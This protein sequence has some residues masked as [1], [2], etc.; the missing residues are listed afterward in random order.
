MPVPQ[1][2]VPEWDG[3]TSILIDAPPAV[4]WRIVQELLKSSD[5]QA[6]VRDSKPQPGTKRWWKR[7]A[8]LDGSLAVVDYAERLATERIISGETAPFTVFY[9]S[10]SYYN[11]YQDIEGR[12]ERLIRIGPSLGFCLIWKTWTQDDTYGLHLDG[13]PVIRMDRDQILV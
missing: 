10:D 6:F 13:Y 3:R 11:Y 7:H 9:I 12:V 2:D 4:G 8:V 5:A 1:F